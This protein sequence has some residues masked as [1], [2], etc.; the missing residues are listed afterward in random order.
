MDLAERHG[1]SVCLLV[2]VM[3]PI[4]LV[5][6][7]W[8]H[9]I[10]WWYLVPVLPVLWLCGRDCHTP[11]ASEP[12]QFHSRDG[13]ALYCQVHAQP[14]VSK[15]P[16]LLLHGMLGSCRCWEP[17]LPRLV[18]AGFHCVA[19]DLL[20]FGRSPWPAGEANYTAQSHCSWIKRG[21]IPKCAEGAL[22]IVGHSLGALLALELAAGMPKGA[23]RGVTLVSM[24]WYETTEEAS[25][26]L[27]QQ[28]IPDLLV[29]WPNVAWV[30]CSLLCQQRWLWARPL[31]TVWRCVGFVVPGLKYPA[32]CVH[33][34]FLHSCE[35]A[36][37]TMNQCILERQYVQAAEKLVDLGVRIT[38]IHGRQ[39]ELVPLD[40]VQR[41]SRRFPCKVH[42]I[43][44][45]HHMCPI[46]HP[47]ALSRILRDQVC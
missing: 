3:L 39:A 31:S 7:T 34:F 16:L 30:L 26:Q 9:P 37:S 22:E 5:T 29:N 14:N 11:G 8:C 6:L 27:H 47:E 43:D 24:P 1:W 44:N 45:G 38:I 42:V 18:Q 2:A 33:D 36:A 15:H 25:E 13:D 40:C 12:P 21:A 35:S 28:W 4:A 20:G 46:H 41:F 10:V 23:V 32:G 17:L 19:V